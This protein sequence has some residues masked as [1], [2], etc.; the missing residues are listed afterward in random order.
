[1]DLI[2]QFHFEEA[3]YVL[4]IGWEKF[5][6]TEFS[7]ISY[8]D[9]NLAIWV[10]VI[11]AAL[12][13]LKLLLIWFGRDKYFRT[14]SGHLTYDKESAGF[15]I[16][17]V[18]VLLYFA[19]LIPISL[20]IIAVADPV[21]NETREEK[22]YVETRTRI[23]IRDISGSMVSGFR[24]TQIL[25]AEVAMN[26]HLEFLKKRRGKG[27]RAS[28]WVF[29]SF[30][31]LVQNF[32]IDDDVYYLQAYDAPWGVSVDPGYDEDSGVYYYG[33]VSRFRFPCM[34]GEGGGT[35]L[36]S[37]LNAAMQKF[38]ED[39]KKQK[40]SPYFKA[41]TNRAI[42]VITD[43]AVADLVEVLK[44]LE[45]LRKRNIVLYLIWINEQA[46][47]STSEQESTNLLLAA[48]E[49]NGGKYFS[50]AD[51]AGFTQAYTEIDNLEVA[52]IEIKNITFKI[53]LFQNFIFATL[54]SLLVIIFLGLMLESFKVP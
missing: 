33:C 36:S 49:K 3:Y 2:K 17:F 23:D 31:H 38:D 45:E 40:N 44:S 50:V 16:K 27:D 51:E 34:I 21:F 10:S 6:N 47:A 19:L 25:K 46:G 8:S 13:L 35:V 7:K 20:I 12:V 29:G 42:V 4:R 14:D 30:P 5:L 9:S 28:L 52:K 37:A 22:V 15:F 1:M 43:A 18:M 11:L 24:N 39:D 26:A 32:I 54:V 48:V 53:P 41:N